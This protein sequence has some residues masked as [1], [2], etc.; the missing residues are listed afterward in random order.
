MISM[1]SLY[2]HGLNRSIADPANPRD[3]PVAQMRQNAQVFA[4]AF[5][6]LAQWIEPLECGA[7]GSSGGAT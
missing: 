5:E 3:V 6:R 4:A 7:A 2:E 1:R